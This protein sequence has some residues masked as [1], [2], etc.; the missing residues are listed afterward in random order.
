MPSINPT[1][2]KYHLTD[3]ESL[4]DSIKT[5]LGASQN[6]PHS[7]SMLSTHTDETRP[8]NKL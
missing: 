4:T 2:I 8:I 6:I 5:H 7:E 3:T 1:L